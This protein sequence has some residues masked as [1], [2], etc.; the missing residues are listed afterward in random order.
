MT[1]KAAARARRL[2]WNIAIAEGRLVRFNDGETFRP[3]R[4]AAAAAL[5]VAAAEEAGVPAHIVDPAL[6]DLEKK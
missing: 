6:A 5:A 2:A 1:K 4:S 3:Y